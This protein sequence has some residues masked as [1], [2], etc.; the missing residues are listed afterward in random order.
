M[1]NV[2]VLTGDPSSL[3]RQL[4]QVLRQGEQHDPGMARA[5]DE[6]DVPRWPLP[7][8]TVW[9]QLDRLAEALD[10]ENLER[11][12]GEGAEYLRQTARDYA[13]GRE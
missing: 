5:L 3:V 12:R 11:C 7:A 1:S 9:D 13:R 2:T 6:L 8:L 4:V 10:D